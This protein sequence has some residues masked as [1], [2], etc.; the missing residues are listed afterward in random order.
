MLSTLRLLAWS[1]TSR[2][3]PVP[4]QSILD[5]KVMFEGDVTYMRKSL[6]E[7][8]RCPYEH[9]Y[10]QEW[11]YQ[12]EPSV[13]DTDSTDPANSTQTLGK[14]GSNNESHCTDEDTD[15]E[16]LSDDSDDESETDTSDEEGGYHPDKRLDHPLVC[17]LEGSSCQSK[18]R[19]LRAASV[20][21]P[22]IAQ[23]QRT[24]YTA[25]KANNTIRDIDNAIQCKEYDSLMKACNISFKPLFKPRQ[26][27][28]YSETHEGGVLNTPFRIPH[29]EAKLLTKYATQIKEF[30]KRVHDYHSHPCCAVSSSLKLMS[31]ISK[32]QMC[33]FK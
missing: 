1:C 13:G 17:H 20:H 10:K 27:E 2:Y 29:L 5:T 24:V 26:S 22:K 15:D 8:D 16:G 11:H 28:P 9:T 12:L 6:D 25:V 30:D 33:G 21:Y 19:I 4:V 31:G 3:K 7:L 18:L 14:G 23:F 32:K